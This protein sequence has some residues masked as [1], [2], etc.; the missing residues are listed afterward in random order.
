M[1]KILF[2][3]VLFLS[4]KSFAQ[5]GKPTAI[6]FKGKCSVILE[7]LRNDFQNDS[8]AVNYFKGHYFIINNVKAKQM[9]ATKDYKEIVHFFSIPENMGIRC[10]LYGQPD[11]W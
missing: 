11:K 1:K 5:E 3:L 8:I 2:L 7:H 6:I 10:C 9:V 4:F